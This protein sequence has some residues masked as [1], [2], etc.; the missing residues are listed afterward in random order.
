MVVPLCL[1]GSKLNGYAQSEKLR[2]LRDTVGIQYISVR[3]NDTVL[4]VF[5][6]YVQ[7]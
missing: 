1:I 6:A 5:I 4:G 3:L 7:L 2:P